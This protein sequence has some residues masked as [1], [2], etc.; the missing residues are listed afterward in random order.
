MDAVAGE[1]VRAKLP[2]P[3]IPERKLENP[4]KAADERA[5]K[6]SDVAAELMRVIRVASLNKPSSSLHTLLLRPE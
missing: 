3:F 5:K 2:D 1:D 6:S 4:E